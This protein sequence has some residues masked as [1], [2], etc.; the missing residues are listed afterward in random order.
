[1]NPLLA[2]VDTRALEDFCKRWKVEVLAVFGSAARGGLTP[3]SDID[4]LVS[5]AP[6]AEWSLLDHVRMQL[7]LSSLIGR[8]VDLV[9]RRAVERS[10]NWIRRRSILESAEVWYAAR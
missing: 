2:S 7:E 1:M 10:H 5:F 3:E 4:L 9:S 8:Q 6:E